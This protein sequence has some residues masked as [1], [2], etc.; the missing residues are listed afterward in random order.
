MEQAKFTYSPL[1][2]VFEKQRKMIEEQSKEENKQ[3]LLEIETKDQLFWPIKMI[4]KIII[5]MYLKNYFKKD[6]IK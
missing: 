3:M 4:K 2:K 1:G 6:L 5:K